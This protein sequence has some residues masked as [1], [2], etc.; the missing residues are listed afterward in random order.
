MIRRLSSL[1]SFFTAEPTVYAHR[2]RTIEIIAAEKGIDLETVMAD[3][4]AILISEG[5]SEAIIK[6]RRRFQ[7][8]LA[9][10]WVFVDKLDSELDL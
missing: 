1:V 9:T 8:P 5:R 2:K 4:R 6:L 7:V 10:A 3:T